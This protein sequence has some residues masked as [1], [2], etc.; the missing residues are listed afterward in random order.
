MAA[1]I[2]AFPLFQNEFL[3]PVLFLIKSSVRTLPIAIVTELFRGDAFYW[4]Q[5]MAGTVL[6]PSPSS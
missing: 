4:G 2:F 6:A 1:L 5:S 3:Y